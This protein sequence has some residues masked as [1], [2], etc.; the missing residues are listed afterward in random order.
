[1]M[2][3][4]D[5]AALCEALLSEVSDAQVLKCDGEPAILFESGGDLV[6]AL[7]RIAHYAPML[8]GIV[9]RFMADMRLHLAMCDKAGSRVMVMFTSKV[10]EEP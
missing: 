9:N 6:K 8:A 10:G 3:A 7:T 5:Y 4:T 1:M 2:G